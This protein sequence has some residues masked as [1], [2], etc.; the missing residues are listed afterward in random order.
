MEIETAEVRNAISK[1]FGYLKSKSRIIII[2]ILIP[3]IS[4][5]L[6]AWL[7][8]PK[9]EA[10]LSFIINES[11]KGVG[12][13]LLSLAGQSGLML[14]S[15][16][17]TPTDDKIT[18]LLSS[19]RILGQA[20]LKT[21]KADNKDV[22]I[23]NALL[24]ELKLN[25]AY[26]NDPDMEGFK[27]F[28]HTNYDQ[29]SEQ[30]YRAVSDLSQALT[31]YKIFEYDVLKKKSL[32]AQS[33]GIILMKT[34]LRNEPLAKAVTDN[35][36]SSLSEFYI[37]NT[38]EKQQ[39]NV[40]L[41][42]HKLDSVQDLLYT[43]EESLGHEADFNFSIT[44]ARGK[45]NELRLRKEVEMLTLLRAELIKNLEL[46]KLTLEQQKPYFKVVDSP[47]LPLKKIKKSKLMF[48]LGGA[49]LG[50]SGALVLFSFLFFRQRNAGKN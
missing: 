35:V 41:F 44:K 34:T 40:N 22:I 14:G 46:A 39:A 21:Y 48:T 38:I 4:G 17:L 2:L 24:E 27:G 10:Q 43:A 28:V 47:E 8:K 42:K 37:S 19:K 5:V 13:A 36:Y 26:A 11:E 32:V 7:R 29:L 23:G 3:A 45:V 1:Y 20:F 9:Y 30:E 33:T 50:F 49:L 16:S 25:N 18:F 6:F 12:S 15:S 31:D